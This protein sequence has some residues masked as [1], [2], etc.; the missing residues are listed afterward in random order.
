MRRQ[1][2]MTEQDLAT[3]MEAMRPVPYMIVGGMGPPSVQENANAA[4]ATLGKRM[5][6]E[7]MS[8]RPIAGLGYRFFSA[9][10]S[11]P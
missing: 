9:E 11:T 2:E 10:D 8:V 1:Y 4:W 5:G 7:P 3:L 6:F